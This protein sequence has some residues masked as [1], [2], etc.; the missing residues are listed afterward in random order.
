MPGVVQQQGF[1]IGRLFVHRHTHVVEHGDHHFQR[2]GINQLV[3]QVIRD[4]AVREVAACFTQLDQGFQA[5]AAFSQVFF[6]QDGF[7]QA[8]F[9]HQGALFRLAE[10]HAQG[11][12]FFCGG[13][14]AGLGSCRGVLDFTF[15]VGL[16]VGEV[17]VVVQ[18]AFFLGLGFAAALGRRFRRGF[19]CL[20]FGCGCSVAVVG[21]GRFAH[22]GG[23]FL[24]C[25]VAGD[26]GV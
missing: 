4:F 22:T 5:R 11:L 14:R 6:G 7:I 19:G 2:L 1:G 18:A 26:S 10:L 25:F 24:G 13:F 21:A 12:G 23:F 15:E 17:G 20:G 9:L 8:K 3:G 16:D